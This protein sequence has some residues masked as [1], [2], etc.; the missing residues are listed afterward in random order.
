MGVNGM[1][2]IFHFLAKLRQI[3]LTDYA[4]IANLVKTVVEIVR[5]VGNY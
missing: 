5:I 1:E 4:A 3:K 2:R